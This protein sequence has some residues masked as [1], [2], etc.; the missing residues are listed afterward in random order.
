[1]LVD[2]P[3]IDLLPADSP[4][5]PAR[6]EPRAPLGADPSP[7][8]LHLGPDVRLSCADVESA[9]RDHRTRFAFTLEARRAMHASC[10]ALAR[11]HAASTEIYGLTTG[12]GPHV[13][14]RAA[15]DAFDQGAGLIAHL[16]AGCGPIADPA[17]VRAAMI[18]RAQAIAQGR[19]GI[20]LPAADALLALLHAGITPVVP[21]VGSVGAS[22]DLIPLS[23]VARVLAGE[24]ECF[25]NGRR[26]PARDALAR[27][28]ITP[29]RLS[30]RDALALVNGTA[31]M[32]AF[33]ALA[34]TRAQRLFLRA[35]HLTGYLYR[36]L[37]CR[38][39][40]LDPRLH[41][42][43]GH[44]NQQRSAE[45]IRHEAAR[46]GPWEDTTRPLQEVYSLRCAP[47]FFGAGRDNI[48]FALD[49]ITREINGVNDN[50]LILA[51]DS[52]SPAILHGGNFQGQ[53]ISFACDALN[54]AIV[55]AAITVERQLDVLVNPE[56]NGGA[57][58]LLAWQPGATS[59]LAGVQI[60]A[61]ALIAEMRH[62]SLPS[63]IASVPTNG[64]NQ[65][66]VSMGTLAARAALG[67]T[68]RLATVL[69]ANAI[70]AAQLNF[71]RLRGRAP[72]RTSPPP[73]WLDSYTPF[74][75]DRPL[76]DD[77]ARFA[78]AFIEPATQPG[79]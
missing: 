51:D 48:A 66:V 4:D 32:T 55:Q 3:L 63:A 77:L 29:L 12:F 61:S 45:S 11:A 34:V 24:H 54:A 59:G 25:V 79:P 69:A 56:L 22:G 70:A 43:R 58:L 65:D 49:T 53:Q 9:A 57:P 7:I 6:R 40:A 35:E 67:Q 38:Q 78:T 28:G 26:V 20:D 73:E 75:A 37:G 76:H 23:H 52:P 74:E 36:L 47:Q 16:A 39:Q 15:A 44:P 1:M 41:A 5:R 30:G 13:Q 17:F 33:A 14:F 21:E 8:T 18:I 68:D 2:Q 46:F 10:E 60:T 31:F 62:H 42:A 50:P 72:G 19:S 27:A 71:L 64:R